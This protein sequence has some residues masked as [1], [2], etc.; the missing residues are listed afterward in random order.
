MIVETKLAEIQEE[1]ASQCEK[2]CL[3]GDGVA[4]FVYAVNNGRT[5]EISV[6]HGGF[7]LEFWETSDDEDAGPLQELTVESAEQA[8]AQAKQW[9]A[10]LE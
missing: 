9:L 5:V 10:A 6:D 8:V 2:V 3:K 7:W 4:S 1:L